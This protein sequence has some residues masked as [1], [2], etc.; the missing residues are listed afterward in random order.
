MSDIAARTMISF[1]VGD[2]RFNHRVAA[3]AIR[4]GHVL[5]CR[6]DEDDY[7]MLPGGRV[8]LGESSPIALAREMAEELGVEAPIERLLFTEENF[9]DR[10][11]EA[12]HQIGIYYQVALPDDFPFVTGAPSLVRFDEGLELKFSWVPATAQ[13]LAAVNLL[14]MWLRDALAAPQDSSRHVVVDERS[15]A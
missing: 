7:V 13:A 2:Q 8:E 5:V 10:E 15:R 1:K 14:P 6:E 12:F 11:G 4:D 3:I 9:F